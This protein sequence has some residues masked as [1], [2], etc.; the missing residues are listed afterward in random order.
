MQNRLQQPKLK[1]TAGTQAKGYNRHRCRI[2]D[3][4]GKSI[5]GNEIMNQQQKN[6]NPQTSRIP[7]FELH[8]NIGKRSKN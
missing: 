6:S 3:T 1:P 2:K 8:R 7:Y 5:E 4:Q